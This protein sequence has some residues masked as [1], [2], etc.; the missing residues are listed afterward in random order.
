MKNYVENPRSL[1]AL[2][3]AL[4]VFSALGKTIPILHA[5]PGCGLQASIGVKSGY[6]GGGTG[7][8]SSNMF[9]KEVVFGGIN[10]LKRNNRRNLRSNG[11]RFICCS[12]RMYFRDY[13]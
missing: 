2:N 10:R 7:C 9:E 4:G 5:G 1:C 11:R 6:V 8:P 3:G 12:Y 13:R